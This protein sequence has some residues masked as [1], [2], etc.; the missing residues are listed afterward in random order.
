MLLNAGK[1]HPDDREVGGC[2]KLS[3]VAK[4]CQ[5]LPQVARSCQKLP[6]VAKSCHKLLKVATGRAMLW[7][8]GKR[9]PDDREGGSGLPWKTDASDGATNAASIMLPSMLPH[10]FSGDGATNGANNMLHHYS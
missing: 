3:P 5:K 6:Q 7:N 4:S 8:A 9:Q 10:C 1:W 2:K